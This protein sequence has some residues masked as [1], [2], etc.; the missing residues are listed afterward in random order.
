MKK[1]L[2]NIILVVLVVMNLVLTG[3]IVFAVVPAMNNTTNLVKKVAEA[4]DLSKEDEKASD[5]DVGIDQTELYN[6]SDKLTVPL[7]KGSDGKDKYVVVSVTLTLNKEGS[8][9]SQYKDKLSS[10]ETLMKSEVSS[11]LMKYNSD[12][13]ISIQDQILNEILQRLQAMFDDTKFI[14]KVAFSSCVPA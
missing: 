3:I 13:V 14:Y 8:G 2:L 10:Y 4:I 12:Q 7:Q 6:F 9:Y 11:V 5:T 1:G